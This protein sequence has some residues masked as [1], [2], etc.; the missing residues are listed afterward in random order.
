MMLHGVGVVLQCM[1]VML[2]CI[3]V[4]LQCIDMV[5]QCMGVEYSLQPGGIWD[6]CYGIPAWGLA[7]KAV[8]KL[9]LWCFGL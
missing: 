6:C 4:V 2:Q 3:G 1:G 7:Y 8:C 9:R 5:L